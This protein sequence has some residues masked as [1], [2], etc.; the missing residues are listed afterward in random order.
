MKR[1]QGKPQV[2]FRVAKETVKLYK[3]R[4]ISL[5]APGVMVVLEMDLLDLAVID[6]LPVL[7]H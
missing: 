7:T 2:P 1:V 4:I 5:I 6:S 3:C